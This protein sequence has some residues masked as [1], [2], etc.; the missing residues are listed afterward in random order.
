MAAGI[1]CSASS[2]FK[3][4]CSIYRGCHRQHPYQMTRRATPFRRCSGAPA[5]CWRSSTRRCS[6]RCISPTPG[7]SMPTAAS[8]TPTSL[9]V[10]AAG[11]LALDGHPAQAWDWGIHKQVQVAML[12]RDYVG[13]Y[14]WHYPPPV[15]VH[16]HGPR[17]ISLCH[18]TGRLGR[19]QLRALPGNDARCRW[20][21][22]RTPCGCGVPVV[23]AN[24]M[25]GQNGFPQPRRCLAEPW[26]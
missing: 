11:K 25:A 18:R 22:V 20:T 19:S 1:G 5:C 4:G 2:F 3:A 14:T 21:T 26:F 8:F 9:N 6:R 17:A 10:W 16:R 7:W 15:P 12:G 13:D 23:L 24:T